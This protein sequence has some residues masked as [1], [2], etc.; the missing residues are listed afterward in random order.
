MNIENIVTTLC[1]ENLPSPSSYQRSEEGYITLTWGD[2]EVRVSPAGISADLYYGQQEGPSMRI[3]DTGNLN[4]LRKKIRDSVRADLP[5]NKA[6]SY[7]E[8]PC[9]QVRV[10]QER[11]Q[12]NALRIEC[13]SITPRCGYL[14]KPNR[15][16][17]YFFDYLPCL[18]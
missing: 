5:C 17:G 16:G 10:E 13:L 18:K 1:G 7:A 15:R 14:L 6:V 4:F 11:L 9:K 3:D 8:C 12:T 2:L